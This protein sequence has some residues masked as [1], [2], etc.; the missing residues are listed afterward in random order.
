MGWEMTDREYVC[1]RVKELGDE[2]IT[3]LRV[4]LEDMLGT[5]AKDSITCRQA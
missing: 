5:D 2:Y 3:R 4:I 1:S